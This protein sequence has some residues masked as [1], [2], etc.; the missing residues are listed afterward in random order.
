[1]QSMVS[2]RT[3]PL[4]KLGQLGTVVFAF[5][6]VSVGPLADRWR[7]YRPLRWAGYTILGFLRTLFGPFYYLA[8]HRPNVLCRSK[9]S[10]R[11]SSRL[12]LSRPKVFA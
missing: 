12:K 7:V 5:G 3:C 4:W 1:M 9:E 2:G 11:S 6:V 8:K 10:W